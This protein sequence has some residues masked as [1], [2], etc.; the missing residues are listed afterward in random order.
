MK[1]NDYAKQS[2]GQNMLIYGGPKTGK[3][4]LTAGLANQGFTLHV[5][6]LEMGAAV[7][8]TVVKPENFGNVNIYQIEDTPKAANAIKTVSHIFN[9]TGPVT[10]CQEHGVIACPSCKKGS[11]E[12]EEIDPTTFGP[13]DVLVIDSLTQLSISAMVHSTGSRAVLS[14]K[15]AEW[16][17]YSAQS[18]LL[19]FILTRAQAAK[20]HTIFISHEGSLEQNDGSEKLAPIGGT[21]NYSRN[22]A[23]FF[24]HVIY[25]RVKNMSH[26]QVSIS[27][28]EASV[29]AGNRY[30]L[31]IGGDVT[32][33]DFLNPS[34]EV[35]EAARQAY[36]NKGKSVA[37][38]GSKP[39]P[40]NKK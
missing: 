7:F 11:K 10:F 20:F 35:L 9:A 34:E 14:T 26:N 38:P 5:L 40:F 27:S 22:I 2:K 3:T 1:L 29:I 32:L 24:D 6:D 39:N 18:Q 13:K 31:D 23:R 36:H 37:K 19:D 25:A 16:D 8:R 28:K 15:K 17:D 30:N 12:F 33:A 21:R 4:A